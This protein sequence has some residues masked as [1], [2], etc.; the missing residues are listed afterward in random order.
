VRDRIFSGQDVEDALALAAATLGLPQGDLR[1]VVLEAGTPGGRGLKPT[2][3]RIAVLLQ[4]SGRN[5][6]QP[7][8]PA[9]GRRDRPE[10]SISP[11]PRAGLQATL[12]A[13][14]EAGGL[15][16]TVEVEEGE[17]AVIVHLRGA[18]T[19]FFLG[20][21]GKGE[22]FRGIE[23]LLQRMYGLALQPRALRLAIPGFRERRDA[24]LADEARRIAAEVRGDGR[25]RTL[26]PQNAYERRVVHVALQDEPG[27]KTFS[28]GEGIERRVT[29]A[30]VGPL[31]GSPPA[32][33]AGDDRSD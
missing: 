32:A 6:P 31:A 30:P 20:T 14:A 29:I 17:D 25:P 9:A 7:D 27:V 22:I 24:A 19:E 26:D 1:Y 18:D 11:D 8:P 23:H 3:A 21:D 16:L 10:S 2:V 4:D 12:R 5:A 13:V 28:V 15:D 33:E